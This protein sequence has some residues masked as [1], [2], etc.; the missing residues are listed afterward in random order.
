MDANI[1]NLPIIDIDNICIVDSSSEISDRAYGLLKENGLIKEKGEF[2]DTT[3]EIVEILCN[4]KLGGIIPSMF[5]SGRHAPSVHELT[6]YRLVMCQYAKGK[7]MS[8]NGDSEEVQEI[9]SKIDDLIERFL[10]A[11]EVYSDN[12]KSKVDVDEARRE[13]E[14]VSVWAKDFYSELAEKTNF[15]K[16]ALTDEAVKDFADKSS[17]LAQPVSVAIEKENNNSVFT[18]NIRFNFSFRGSWVNEETIFAL[19]RLQAK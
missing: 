18:K 5:K 2:I 10:K 3:K 8:A 15:N 16:I 13:M 17:K 9:Q 12:K 7:L 14:Y 19:S 4:E 11:Y 1:Q 6:I